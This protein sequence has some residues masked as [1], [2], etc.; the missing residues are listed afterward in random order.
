MDADN[1]TSHTRFVDSEMWASHEATRAS[2]TTWVEMGDTV[3]HLEEPDGT[4]Y[5]T[6][7]RAFYAVRYYNDS[8]VLT[9]R[10]HN[11]TGI[12]ANDSTTDEFQISRGTS[13]GVWNVYFDGT[14][15]TT[16]DLNF[17]NTPLLQAGGE[18]ATAY[19]TSDLFTMYLDGINA[20]GSFVNWGTQTQ[21]V[22]GP[23]YGN[24]PSNSTW[25]WRVPA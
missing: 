8:G 17:W 23:L 19:G 20:S 15:R 12:A 13:N 2:S 25:Q 11:I 3:G 5:Y 22:D 1:D 18:V 16:A 6:G 21:T 10:E 7:Y 14:L 24:H 9:Y 4:T